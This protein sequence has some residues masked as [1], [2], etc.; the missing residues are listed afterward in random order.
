M[1]KTLDK[2]APPGS[3]GKGCTSDHL[4]LLKIFQLM[5]GACQA[6]SDKSAF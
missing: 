6:Y 5:K 2:F 3:A 4:S 1:V